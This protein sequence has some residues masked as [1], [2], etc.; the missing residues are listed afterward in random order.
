MTLGPCAKAVV[1]A[2]LIFPDGTEIIG[3]NAVRHPQ[4]VCPRI[5]H[6]EHEARDAYMLCQQ[7]CR[8]P[9]HA[10]MAAIDIAIKAGR[11]LDGA[12]MV[13]AHKRICSD[14]EVSLRE[15]GVAWECV[16]C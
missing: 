11:S 12:R 2:R 9:F 8:Q 15:L 3:V 6:A 16:P 7:R 10:E 4:K 1:K 13:I 14:C 5:G